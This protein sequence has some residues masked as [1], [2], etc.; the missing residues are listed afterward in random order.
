MHISESTGLA[1]ISV[2]LDIGRHHLA[3]FGEFLGESV[4]VDV[5]GEF[6]DKD[7]FDFFVVT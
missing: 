3:A 2:H 4:R 5:P 6:A 7:G 1:R